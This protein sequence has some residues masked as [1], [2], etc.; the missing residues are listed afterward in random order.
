V[1]GAGGERLARRLAALSE[2]EQ[3]VAVLAEEAETLDASELADVLAALVSRGVDGRRE[4]DHAGLVAVMDY[5]ESE[6]LGL[7]RRGELLKAARDRNHRH[8]LRLLLSPSD[9]EQ[10]DEVRVPDYGKGRPLTLG[11]R[12][13]LARRPNRKVLERVLADPHPAVI[14]NL[15]LNPKLTETDVLKLVS[16]RPLPADVLRELYRSA[17][18]GRRYR[19]KVAIVRNPSTPP[20]IAT[21]LL[22]QLM[23]QDLEEVLEDQGLHPSVIISCRRLLEGESPPE[24][25][26][27]D[28]G[29]D[30]PTLH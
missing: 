1:S 30:G 27:D 15:L 12:K 16:R 10:P 19:I 22:P 17:R 6:L 2:P 9:T 5:L 7:E 25:E 29:G 13:S 28:E 8:L 26:E 21:K 3:R 18:W 14:H 23:R 24:L 20:S 11:E 4:Q